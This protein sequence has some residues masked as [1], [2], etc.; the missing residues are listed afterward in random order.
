MVR[1]GS[2]RFCW[3][4]HLGYTLYCISKAFKEC[5]GVRKVFSGFVTC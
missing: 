4:E 3:E 1:C 5:L 2:R